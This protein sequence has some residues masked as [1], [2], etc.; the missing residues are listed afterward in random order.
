[1]KGRAC[2]TKGRNIVDKREYEKLLCEVLVGFLI[3]GTK[4]SH[5]DNLGTVLQMKQ[6]YRESAFVEWAMK[7][8]DTDPGP[9]TSA[10]Y[11]TASV[12]GYR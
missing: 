1:M 3:N 10:P 7:D 8:S 9:S 5:T 6:P 4:T 2:Q 12:A 11:D